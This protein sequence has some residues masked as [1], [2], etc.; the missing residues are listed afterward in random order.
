MVLIGRDDE[1]LLARS[2]HFKPGVFSALAGFVEAGETLEQ[3]A[4]R[5]V[6][7]EVGIEIANLRYFPVSYTHLDVYK[8]QGNTWLRT[9]IARCWWST[10]IRSTDRRSAPS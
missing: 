3:C 8:R 1:L 7:E 5:E 6:R 9:R 4:V 10:I 2:P